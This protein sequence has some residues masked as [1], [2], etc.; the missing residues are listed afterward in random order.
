MNVFSIRLL[1]DWMHA[2][3]ITIWSRVQKES[4]TNFFLSLHLV[5][6]CLSLVVFKF[7]HFVRSLRTLLSISISLLLLCMS[8]RLS[9]W[10][11]SHPFLFDI[12]FVGMHDTFSCIHIPIG[13]RCMMCARVCLVMLEHEITKP[14]DI[15]SHCNQNWLIDVFFSRCCLF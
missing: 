6:F 14:V 9:F 12:F 15:T 8:R 3:F 1:L 11:I 13:C 7:V 5:S 10:L 4:A 2:T